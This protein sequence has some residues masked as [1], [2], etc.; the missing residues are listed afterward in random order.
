MEVFLMKRKISAMVLT[1]FLAASTI[2]PAFAAGETQTK[3]AGITPDSILYP[4]DKAIEAIQ[5]ALTSS[6]IK[7]AELL[8]QNAE[9]RLAEVQ[10]MLDKN[11]I[12][13]A[14]N[15]AEDYSETAEKADDEVQK[16]S[17]KAANTEDA[18]KAEALKAEI[19]KFLEE[20]KDVQK[21]SVEVLEGLLTKLPEEARAKVAANIVKQTL[22]SEAVKKFVAAK[23]QKKEAEKALDDA[24]KT[25]DQAKIAE[26]QKALD[27]IAADE[28][29]DNQ[30]V[31]NDIEATIDGIFNRLGIT[32]K[33]GDDKG[34]IDKDKVKEEVEKDQN[35]KTNNGKSQQAKENAKGQNKTGQKK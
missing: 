21:H 11:K 35:D 18:K 14:K 34:I 26:A 27:A 6:N 9:E 7:K 1:V 15:T 22:H 32:A 12:D 24:K 10:A 13:I 19:D 28:K 25:G 17:D 2:T 16:A 31:K 20:H 23:K 30:E 3:G 33:T 4:V 8:A 29:F 5:L